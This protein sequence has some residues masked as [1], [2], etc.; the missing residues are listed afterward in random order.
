MTNNVLFLFTFSFVNRI[1]GRGVG[2]DERSGRVGGGLGDGE[3]AVAAVNKEGGGGAWEAVAAMME[4]DR[5]SVFATSLFVLFST[6][7][8]V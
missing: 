2:G 6:H 3:E 8:R 4:G 5:V 1:W 7:Y